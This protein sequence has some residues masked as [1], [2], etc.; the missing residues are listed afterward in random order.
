[1]SNPSASYT[2][3]PDATYEAELSALAGVYTFVLDWRKK[4]AAP[5]DGPK[6]RRKDSDGRPAERILQQ[7][8]D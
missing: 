8:R 5:A 4:K 1:M 6:T 7:A 3:R 2:P